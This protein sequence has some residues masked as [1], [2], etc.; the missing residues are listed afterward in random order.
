MVSFIGY[1]NIGE[2]KYRIEYLL[3]I[4]NNYSYSFS[5][6]KDDNWSY[7]ITKSNNTFS[8]LSTVTKGIEYLFSETKPDS[9]IFTAIDDNKTRKSLY[10]KFCNDFC[11][12]NDYK[13]SNRGNEKLVMF[14]I[15]NDRLNN[16]RKE[17]IF[18]S[19]EKIVE[20]GK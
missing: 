7:D 12:K 6:F 2:D 19:A 10:E 5:I 3:Q 8:V 11:Q 13:L 9:I 14:I 16:D 15:F 4:G 18:Q 1:F 17:L 20:I